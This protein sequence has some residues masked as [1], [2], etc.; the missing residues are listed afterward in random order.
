[1][2]LLLSSPPHA[3]FGLLDDDSV[4]GE[5]GADRIGFGEVLRHRAAFIWSILI[6]LLVRQCGRVDYV[7]Q[8][9]T[10]V[11]FATFGFAHSKLYCIFF[12]ARRP[13]TRKIFH[14]IVQV[15]QAMAERRPS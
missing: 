9:R 3:F 10:D 2:G 15:Q 13:S 8:R 12:S 6:D 4:G 5:F 7:E 11:F 14:R 1:M